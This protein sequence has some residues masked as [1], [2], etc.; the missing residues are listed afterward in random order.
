M[1]IDFKGYLLYSSSLR[2]FIMNEEYA[3]GYRDGF[4]DGSSTKKWDDRCPKCGIELKGFL[5][6]VCG[7]SHCP[8][9]PVVWSGDIVSNN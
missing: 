3:R 2:R 7:Q 4:R 5:G 6:Y 8:I 9:M 1:L